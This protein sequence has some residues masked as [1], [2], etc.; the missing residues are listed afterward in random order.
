MDL[1]SSFIAVCLTMK[2]MMV[3]LLILLCG[4][5]GPFPRG[6]GWYMLFVIVP[7]CL[8][9][10]LSGNLNGLMCLHPLSV[11][12]MLLIGPS[13]P[14]SWFNGWLF[15]VPCIGMQ[16]VLDLGVGGVSYVELLIL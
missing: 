9:H 4:R 16:V 2:E 6:D 10:L 14:V 12:M 13:L 3:L 11:L 7:C 1:R 15:L 8:G 5:L